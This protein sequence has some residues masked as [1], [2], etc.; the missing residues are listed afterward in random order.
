MKITVANLFR[1]AGLAAIGC[2]VCFI[3]IQAIHPPETL[4][5]VTT[6]MWTIT[7]FLGIVMALLGLLGVSGIYAF[8]V[9]AA[10]WAGLIGFLLFGLFFAL[11]LAFQFIEALI[12]P[13][14]ALV[15][16]DFVLGV[17]GIVG[18]YESTVE[19]G[20]LPIAFA[21]TGLVG[22]LLGGVLFGFGTWRGGVLPRWAGALLAL[23]VTLPFLTTG[24]IPHPY[25]RVL[26]LPVGLAIA[27]LGYGLWR[28]QRN[29][30]S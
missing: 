2:G 4:S 18:G 14:L 30:S 23:G 22:Y 28:S 7:H 11:T 10:G 25:D 24:L 21:F 6:L 26:A 15:A 27:W 19:L 12:L 5:D 8:Q 9:E 3:L 16:P 1:G 13:P 17:F 20:A 29:R